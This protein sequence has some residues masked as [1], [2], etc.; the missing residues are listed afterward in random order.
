MQ[1]QLMRRVGLGILVLGLVLVMAR[2]PLFAAPYAAMVMDARNGEVIH[3]RNHDTKLHPASLTKMMTLYIAFEAVKH[4]E[5]GLDTKFKVSRRATR[6]E[7]VCLGL[8]K[9][10][11]ISLR[12]L[13]RAAALRSAN[14]AAVVIAEGI[15]GSVEAFAERMTRTAR[16]M[17]MR[18]TTFKNPHGLTQS[19]HVS[20]ARDMTTLGRQL[21]FDYPQYFNIFSRRSDF[22][23]VGNVPNTNRRFLNAYS[24]AN[25]IKTGYT[26]AAGF[27]LTASAQ[28]G[29]KHIIATMFGGSSTAARN[30]R[31]AEL[32]DM[33][34]S[35]A[36]S[37][38]AV[39]APGTPAYQ[40]RGN[41]LAAKPKNGDDDPNA[42]AKTIRIVTAVRKS[43]RPRARPLPQ[44]PDDVLVA[45]A[46]RVDVAVADTAAELG[47]T[48]LAPVALDVNPPARPEAVTAAVDLAVAEAAGF[49]LADPDDLAALEQSDTADADAAESVAID[50]D[51]A[52]DAQ[53]ET[54]VAV[55]QAAQDTLETAAETLADTV[56]DSLAAALPQ[57]QAEPAADA[58]LETETLAQAAHPAPE[59]EALQDAG[60]PAEI[61]WTGA[62][63]SFLPELQDNALSL[64]ADLDVTVAPPVI[65]DSG[66]I[67]TRSE[68]S[69]EDLMTALVAEQFNADTQHVISRVSSS[70]ADRLWGISLGA[71]NTRHAA[72]RS[73]I[74]VKMAEAQALS[75]G[76]SRIR[77]TSGRFEA[78]FAGLTQGE[79]DRACARLSARGM[80][81]NVARP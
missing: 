30:K 78:S 25:G 79:A 60:P 6:A 10:Q 47:Q 68:T 8:K 61:L 15:S 36:K 16:A 27:N 58:A 22:A 23:G 41:M 63:E 67:L 2:A 59:A 52:S 73:L 26:R 28:R 35:R 53:P 3:A 65:E 43:P 57:A 70:N 11:T 20:T 13:I 44:V 5:V 37:R 45:V 31:V 4:G 42:G 64:N 38:V 40:G 72:E 12:Y 48:K 71:F 56:P 34:F 74:T 69:D 9:G 62:P 1:A 46:E 33:G 55:V 14:D 7:C 77:Q 51:T 32:L 24:G 50:A 29:S 81:C 49:G 54:E 21:F 76:I 75:S 18:N 80:D 19:G 66:I 39:R 17:G